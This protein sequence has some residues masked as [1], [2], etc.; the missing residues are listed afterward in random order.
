MAAPFPFNGAPHLVEKLQLLAAGELI[1]W[2]DIGD[3]FLHGFPAV[4][5][6][7][8]FAYMVRRKPATAVHS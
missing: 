1:F 8:K 5:L 4:I 6:A 3:L 7:A 2:A